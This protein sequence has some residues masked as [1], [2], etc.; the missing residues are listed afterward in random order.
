MPFI[1]IIIFAVIAVLL[2]IRLRSVLGQR[3]GYEQPQVERPTNRFDG[4]END[5]EVIPL[6]LKLLMVP[7][8]L[9]GLD[10]LRQIDRNFNEKEFI[11][12]AKSAFEMILN[13][14]CRG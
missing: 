4:N 8:T 9:H 2:V 14:L 7:L 6:H 1:D 11:S 3:S 12:G 5:S 10:A 13:C